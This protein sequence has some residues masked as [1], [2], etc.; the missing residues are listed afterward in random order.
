MSQALPATLGAHA[1]DT[2]LLDWLDANSMTGGSYE[3]WTISFPGP[4]GGFDNIRDLLRAAKAQQEA[5]K[6][7]G[8]A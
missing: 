3:N 4:A 7:E 6:A 2:A 8:A 1:E 5:E